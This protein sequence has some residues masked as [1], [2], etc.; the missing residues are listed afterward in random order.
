V[1][2][3]PR[4]RRMLRIGGG[5]ILAAA[6]AGAALGL[7]MF[8]VASPANLDGPLDGLLRVVGVSAVSG[9]MI[10]AVAL[11]PAGV[12][13]LVAERYAIRNAA[14]FA[15]AG[16]AVPLVLVLPNLLVA[17]GAGAGVWAGVLPLSALGALAGLVYWSRAGRFSGE[18]IAGQGDDGGGPA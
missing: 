18:E 12:A 9:L 3:S 11:L 14:Y 4:L 1:S 13:I 6:I 16:A 8:V 17:A 10:G 7:A 5:F 2:T 15:L